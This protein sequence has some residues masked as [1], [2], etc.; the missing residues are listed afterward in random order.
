MDVPDQALD[1]SVCVPT[2]EDETC[3]DA[4]DDCDGRVDE[5]FDLQTDALHCGDCDTSCLRPNANVACV[6][7]LCEQSSCFDGF[8]DLDMSPAAPGCEYRCPVFPTTSEDCNGLDDDCDGNIDEAVDLP[9]PPSGLCRTTAGTPCEGTVPVCETRNGIGTW[10]CDYNDQVEFDPDIPSGVVLQETRCDGFDG[11][12]DGVADDAFPTLATDCDNGDLGACRDEGRVVCD[13]A[14]PSQ[15]ICD[16]SLGPNPVPGAPMQEVCNNIDDNCDG[17]L[18]NSSPTDPERV[19][20]DLVHI[21]HNGMDFYMYRYEASRPDASESDAGSVSLR[22][23]S[24]A[25]VVPWTT[26][27]QS[28]AAAACAAAGFRLCTGAEWQT[29]C[30]AA[31]ATNYPYGDTYAP[32]TC[33][34]GDRDAV[35]GGMV[36]H[37]V[38]TTGALAACQSADGIFDLSGNVKEWTNDPRTG[39]P[40]THV[41]RGGSFESPALGLTCQ[42]DLSQALPDTAQATLGFRCCSDVA[43]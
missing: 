22:S 28:A 9:A 13:P 7:A 1:M 12:C 17:I 42:T 31:S 43:P 2:G 33:N 15:T 8:V 36:D 38:S 20:D 32:A 10:Y 26:V 5:D 37:A 19:V 27:G 14:D 34:G 16:F 23:C 4:D 39:P 3:N 11:D 6:D 41:I 35:P 40:M 21:T 25:G 18:D 29:A 30:E 24:N